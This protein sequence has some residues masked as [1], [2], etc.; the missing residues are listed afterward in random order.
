MSK[1]QHYTPNEN[2]IILIDL[3]PVAGKEIG[4]LRPALV[5][6]SKALNEKTGTCFIIPISTSIRGGP[7]EVP[8][9]NLERKSVTCPNLG[10][11]IDFKARHTKKITE[12]ESGVLEETTL[13]LMAILPVNKA[14]AY[15][16]NKSDN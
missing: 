4:K 1:S 16:R 9:N 2:D 8:V 7:L 10:A 3:D 11:T 12:A 6:T 15:A 14:M 13:K 5:M